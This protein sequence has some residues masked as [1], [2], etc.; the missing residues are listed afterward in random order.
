[1]GERGIFFLWSAFQYKDFVFEERQKVFKMHSCLFT[2]K[3]GAIP[4][5]ALLRG[6]QEY[7]T[8]GGCRGVSSPFSHLQIQPGPPHSFPSCTFFRAQ[9]MIT[10]NTQC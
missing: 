7:T 4:G 8:W 6:Q 5:L 3:L 2:L 1:M 10:T 9:L